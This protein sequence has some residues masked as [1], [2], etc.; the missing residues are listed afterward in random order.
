ML[1]PGEFIPLAEETGLIIPL[2]SW[3]LDE[4]CQQMRQW[5]VDFPGLD[6]LTVS[7]NISGNQLRLA[8]F[9]AE[10]AAALEKSALPGSGLILEITENA[11]IENPERINSLIRQLKVIGVEC[12]IDDF[13]TGYS[14]MTHLRLYPINCAK[15]DRSFIKELDHVDSTQPSIVRG[16]LSLLND[17]GIHSIAE[18][19]ETEAQL[20]TLRK[21]GCLYG[22]GYWLGYPMP[23]EQAVEWLAQQARVQIRA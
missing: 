15:I 5:H 14:S 19:I 2:G 12:E 23:A 20:N 3:I 4:A 8:N 13:G 21:M 1:S 11:W 22:Q 18:G 17:L 10:V 7:V 16:M 9:P 6:N